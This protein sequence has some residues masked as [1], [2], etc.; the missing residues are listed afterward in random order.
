MIIT[1]QRSQFDNVTLQARG[2]EGDGLISNFWRGTQTAVVLERPYIGLTSDV[3]GSV[4]VNVFT[5][6]L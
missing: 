1:S 6:G 2:R 5:I 4:V 3:S